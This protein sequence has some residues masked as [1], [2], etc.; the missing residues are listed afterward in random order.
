MI[1]LFAAL[2][3]AAQPSIPVPPPPPFMFDVNSNVVWSCDVRDPS[4][5]ESKIS[6]VTKSFKKRKEDYDV[7]TA[8]FTAVSQIKSQK[9]PAFDGEFETYFSTYDS[10]FIVE[11]QKGKSY[12]LTRHRLLLRFRGRTL[13]YP[14]KMDQAIIEV[15]KTYESGTSYTSTSGLGYCSISGF[16]LTPYQ[17]DRSK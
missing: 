14:E 4:G 13:P 6:G 7:H 8:D 9:H 5:N 16:Q 3:M 10:R 11:V 1:Y 17:S 2:A 15:G 12:P